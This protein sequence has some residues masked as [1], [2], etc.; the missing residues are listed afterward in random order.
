MVSTLVFSRQRT[1]T[2]NIQR[3]Q[4]F[5]NSKSRTLKLAFD[6]SF[7]DGAARARRLQTRYLFFFLPLEPYFSTPRSKMF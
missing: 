1:E 7:I 5:A 2:E 3:L 4:C 6:V